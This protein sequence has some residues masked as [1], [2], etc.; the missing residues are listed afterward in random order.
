MWLYLPTS[1][2][3]AQAEEDST[4]DSGSLYKTLEQSATW[5]TKSRRA[6]S[7]RTIWKKVGWT[8]RLFGQTYEP[9]TAQRGV[10]SWIAS[11]ADT[12]ASRSVL[13][14]K[15]LEQ[16]THGISGLTCDESWERFSREYASSRTSAL[17]CDLDSTRSPETFK[18]WATRLRQAC[19]QRRKLALRTGASGCSSW[20]TATQNWQTPN[21]AAEAPNLGSNIKNGPKSLMAQAD[22]V[23][24]QWGTPTSR[25]W[26]DG[27]SPSME[28]PTNGL[29]GR[30]APR[31]AM[32]GD[33]SLPPDQTSRRRLNPRFVEWLMGWPDGYLALT[34]STFSVTE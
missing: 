19:L 29:L 11:L 6:A 13:Q 25:D 5:K 1:C 34:N 7:W 8:T 32:P 16:L 22:Q 17:I 10:E 15:G 9:S 28:A 33:E 18:A 24:P 12:R 21:A 26:K 27:A 31:T 30:Q 23:T 4:S 20:P 2:R 3:S 14:E